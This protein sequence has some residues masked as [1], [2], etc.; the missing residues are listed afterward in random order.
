MA[1][2]DSTSGGA[3]ANSY[4]DV[5]FADDFLSTETLYGTDWAAAT[6]GNKQ[7]AL[8]MATRDIDR[9]EF[10]G[11][12]N[13]ETQALKWP[14]SGVVLDGV[15]HVSTVIPSEIKQA[16]CLLAN[17]L[18][19]NNP[20]ALSSTSNDGAINAIK[21]GALAVNFDTSRTASR[22][23]LFQLM[24]DSVKALLDDFTVTNFGNSGSVKVVR[25]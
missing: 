24:P 4:V 19:T 5:A 2:F 22:K 11:Y 13:S 6:A 14:R 1:T 25:V 20:D 8:I 16:A 3:S 23:T 17:W 15:T 21:V 10:Y 9:L 18:L 7:A 12:R